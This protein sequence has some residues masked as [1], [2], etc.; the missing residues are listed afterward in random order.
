MLTSNMELFQNYGKLLYLLQQ[1][2]MEYNPQG[3]GRNNP[4]FELVEGQR[5]IFKGAWKFTRAKH[6]FPI[7]R[8]IAF[9]SGINF[10]A[11]KESLGKISAQ[12]LTNQLKLLQ[13]FKLVARQVSSL[14]PLSVTYELTEFG[15]QYCLMSVPFFIFFLLKPYWE[16]IC[17]D[18]EKNP[19]NLILLDGSGF[20]NLQKKFDFFMTTQGTDRRLGN[21]TIL[22]SQLQEKAIRLIYTALQMTKDLLGK[23]MPDTPNPAIRDRIVEK[24]TEA[25]DTLQGKFLFDITYVLYTCAP[26]SFNDIKRRLPDINSLTL[27][28]R[29]KEL[30]QDEI[31]TRTVEAETP[32]RVAYNLTPF[33]TRLLC[34]FWPLITVTGLYQ[35]EA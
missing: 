12:S 1:V 33:G 17:Q 6:V 2:Y 34:M 23:L 13:D 24:F 3:A 11:L 32:L 7:L 21:G 15:T 19:P 18:Y 5:E 27:S 22:H 8:T 35:L 31:L 26:L 4:S 28:T 14:P 16:V 30:E 25:L 29:L 9:S 10:N 20:P